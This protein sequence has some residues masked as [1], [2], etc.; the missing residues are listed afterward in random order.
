MQDALTITTSLAVL[1]FTGVVLSWLAQKLKLPD[2][3]FLLLAGL[4][5]GQLTLNEAPLFA[6]PQ[7]FISS[8]ALIALALIVFD[9]TARL[10]LRELDTFSTKALKVTLVTIAFTLIFFT[11]AAYTLGAF[12]FWNSLLLAAL[13]TGTSS[14]AVLSS[15][16][17]SR[18]WSILKFE[19]IF[20]T[21]FTVVL[22]FIV[23]DLARTTNTNLIEQMT[24]ILTA[25]VVGI[26]AGVFIGVIL[27]KL[28]HHVSTKIY[29][30]LAVI[31]SALLSYVLAENLGGSGVLAVSALGLFFGNAYAERK[32]NLLGAESVLAKALYI[33][34]F[35]LT[36]IIIKLPL[37]LEFIT[38]SGILFLAY[39]AIRF[40]ALWIALHNQHSIKE[41]T[42]MTLIA[43]K[44]I[45][46]AAVAFSLIALNIPSLIPLVKITFAFIICSIVIS[47]LAAFAM[48]THEDHPHRYQS[49]S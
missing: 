49:I 5:L 17:K 38:L 45:A 29:S 41:L 19:S 15:S 7:L 9:C 30:P 31:I 40:A 18:A 25:I 43:P 24:P 4:G 42:A 11:L 10:R 6:V 35:I 16:G 14:E 37:T 20:N 2:M 48:P 23:L 26:G 3:L 1:L 21:P 12:S 39:T 44:G 36:G 13:L 46:T 32:I 22:P 27:F 33:L 28:V 34:V 47:S 8:L